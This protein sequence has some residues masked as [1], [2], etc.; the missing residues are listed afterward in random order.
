MKR[1]FFSAV[2]AAALSLA[3]V[4]GAPA[5]GQERQLQDS[6]RAGLAALGVDADVIP[7]LTTSQVTEI[8]AVLN[9][10]DPRDIKVSRIN[11]IVGNEA[12]AT[13]R[14]GVAQL[15]DSVGAELSK[16][17]VDAS[18]V[19]TLSLSQLAEIESVTSGSAPMDQKRARVLE[20]MG[21]NEGAGNVGRWGVR[22]L[23]ASVSAD[24]ARLGMDTEGVELLS[25][26]ELGE[27]EAVMGSSE[28]DQIKEQ[29]IR[30]IMAN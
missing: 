1:T 28:T 3:L 13:G 4:A 19:N 15:Q 2:S 7:A 30:N 24:M 23:Q 18:A 11:Q 8:E 25:L 10:S 9:G 6:T 16:I 27:I 21:A 14:L 5:I 29:R 20:I 22:Q 17:G 12:T 26:S